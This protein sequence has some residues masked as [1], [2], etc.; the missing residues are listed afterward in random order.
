MEQGLHQ[1]CVLAPLLFSI[2]FAAVFNMTYICFK[3]DKRHHARFG[4]SEEEIGGGGRGGGG[5]EQP[6]ERRS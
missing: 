2:F 6:I 4:A 5:G 1:G 3:A